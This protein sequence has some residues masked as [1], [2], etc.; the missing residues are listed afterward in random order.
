MRREFT[1]ASKIRDRPRFPRE[2]AIAPAA[3]PPGAGRKG[4]RF[5]GLDDSPAWLPALS[6]AA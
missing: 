2:T 6:N 1:L 4:R 3:M 5:Q